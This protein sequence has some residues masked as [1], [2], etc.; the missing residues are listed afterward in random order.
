[1]NKLLAL[2]L[3]KKLNGMIAASKGASI[4]SVVWEPG[5]C[6]EPTVCLSHVEDVLNLGLRVVVKTQHYHWKVSSWIESVEFCCQI[7]FTRAAMM[8]KYKLE[9][10][11]TLGEL[12]VLER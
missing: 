9:R 3:A 7:P 11:R 12:W 6:T 5:V 4:V 1:M 8:D 10:N 2:R